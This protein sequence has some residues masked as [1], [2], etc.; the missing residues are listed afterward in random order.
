[1]ARTGFMKRKSSSFVTSHLPATFAAVQTWEA[2]YALAKLDLGSVERNG[3]GEQLLLS[4]RFEDTA[5]IF[6]WVYFHFTRRP[7][8]EPFFSRLKKSL[9]SSVS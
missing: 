9:L 2:R 7:L 5:K 8:R 3:N 6:R 1:M 4:P